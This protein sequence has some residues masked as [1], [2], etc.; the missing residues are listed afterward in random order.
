MEIETL[1]LVMSWQVLQG[2]ALEH[3]AHRKASGVQSP[4]HISKGPVVSDVHF[5]ILKLRFEAGCFFTVEPILGS[6][7]L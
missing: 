1:V 4:G 3:P 7:G 5:I 6:V 2:E